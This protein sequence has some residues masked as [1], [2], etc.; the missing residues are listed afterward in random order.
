MTHFQTTIS[1]SPDGFGS[2]FRRWVAFIGATQ[3]P[4]HVRNRIGQGGSAALRDCAVLLYAEA[5]K[6]LAILYQDMAD[7]A[8]RYN[9]D[10]GGPRWTLP[11][12]QLLGP[13]YALRGR[14]PLGMDVPAAFGVEYLQLALDRVSLSDAPARVRRA[15]RQAS[16]CAGELQE[17]LEN[18]TG[19]AGGRVQ[20]VHTVTI[21]RLWRKFE[22]AMSAPGIPTFHVTVRLDQATWNLMHVRPVSNI[23][24]P[25]H[26]A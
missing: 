16:K 17:A 26:A 6:G 10:I 12:F 1:L 7:I 11:P 15:T 19:C 24:G 2:S 3:P 9:L 14:D 20:H 13:S 21:N 8:E 5:F 18:V 4:I 23:G 22:E 25:T